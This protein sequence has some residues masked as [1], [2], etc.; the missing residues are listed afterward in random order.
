MEIKEYFNPLLK[1]WW[2]II[3]SAI[4]A[5]G[6]SFLATRQQVPEFISQTTLIIGSA[7]DNPNPSNNDLYL[8]RQL[9]ATYVDLAGRNSVREAAMAA[10][11]MTWLPNIRVFQPTNSN[12]IEIIVTDTD[13][14]RAQAVA[15]ELARQL[16]LR[17]PAAQDD[18]SARQ[19]FVNEQLDEYEQA[20]T[21]TKD[22]ITAK[23]EELGQLI[24]AREI[25]SAQDEIRSLESKLQTLQSIYANL[26]QGTGEGATNTVRILEEA[27][28]PRRPIN[29]NNLPTILTAAAIGFAL[30]AMAAYILEYLDDSVKTPVQIERLVNVPTLAGIGNIKSA[31]KQNVLVTVNQPKSTMSEAYRVL[32]TGIQFSGIDKQNTILLVT[33]AVPQEGKS[34]TAAN[35]SVVLAQAGYRVLLLD[36]DLR[37]PSQHHVFDLPNS[38]GLTT[39]LLQMDDTDEADTQ[40]LIEDVAHPAQV[41]GLQVVTCGPLPPNPSELL[42]SLRMKHLLEVVGGEFDYVVVDSPPVLSVT[43]GVILAAQAGSTI[44]VVQANKS[45]ED[46]LKQTM[47]RL[48]DVNANVVGCVLNLLKPRSEGYQYYRYFRDPYYM[49]NESNDSDV[50][51]DAPPKRKLLK[52]FNHSREAV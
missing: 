32:R 4:I 29:S 37:R 2:L 44:V 17:S 26:L 5:G 22:Q 6:A 50:A 30:A 48:H 38:R 1:W 3:L 10:L 27:S 43:D 16:I 47:E 11:G 49:S 23:K 15:S 12:T 9:A 41:D 51:G 14:V 21:E 18:R 28:L 31:D 33:S 19:D 34:T 39:I 20:I 45:R 7:I 24:S 42:G 36:A 13:P 52:R 8:S 40:S 35:L 46:D 25:A